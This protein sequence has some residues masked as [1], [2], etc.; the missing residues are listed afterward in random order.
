MTLTTSHQEH[1]LE[2]LKDRKYAAG[3]L[4]ACAE[5]GQEALLV[6]LKDVAEALGNVRQIS[7]DTGL[8]RE[9]LYRMLSETGN[10]RLDSFLLVLEW[11]GIDL[12]FSAKEVS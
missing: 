7:E 4:S 2:R 8:N 1:L 5:E 12:S 6:G 11:A 10:P 9:N 3:Y